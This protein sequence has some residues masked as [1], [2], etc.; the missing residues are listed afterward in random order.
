MFN[1]LTSRPKT[2]LSVRVY[3]AE[4]GSNRKGNFLYGLATV[5]ISG[6]LATGSSEGL[7]AFGRGKRT[8]AM[9]GRDLRVALE[10]GIGLDRVIAAKSRRAAETGAVFS[11][12]MELFP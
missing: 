9:E 10:R 5:A 7:D 2:V 12:V 1:G 4:A 3:S 8:I 6:V 11:P